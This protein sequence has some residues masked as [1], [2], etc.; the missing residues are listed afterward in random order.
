VVWRRIKTEWRGSKKFSRRTPRRVSPLPCSAGADF[1]GTIAFQA[2][3]VLEFLRNGC[4]KDGGKP[5]WDLTS[6]PP[7][8]LPYFGMV[9]VADK[10][11]H[12]SG[13]VLQQDAVLPQ[14]LALKAPPPNPTVP[15]VQSDLSAMNMDGTFTAEAAF[16]DPQ[17]NWD[18]NF[19]VDPAFGGS[20]EIG[21]IPMD[22]EAWSSVCLR[23]SLLRALIGSIGIR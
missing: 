13:V 15:Q 19:A 5:H 11:I 9:R 8:I 4:S 18:F 6:P 14:T 17:F 2:V 10:N 16:G 12:P 20:S 1:S 21:S 3:Q 7:I 22:I 23:F